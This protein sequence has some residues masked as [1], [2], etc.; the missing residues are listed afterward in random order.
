MEYL[1]TTI[2]EGIQNPNEHNK[3]PEKKTQNIFEM[4]RVTREVFLL[5]V[6]TSMSGYDCG[7][8]FKYIEGTV[9]KQKWDIKKTRWTRTERQAQW[10]SF[11]NR[12]RGAVDVV[13]IGRDKNHRHKNDGSVSSGKSHEHVSGIARVASSGMRECVQL[14]QLSCP[15]HAAGNWIRTVVILLVTLYVSSLK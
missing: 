12:L 2:P 5:A 10:K 1:S 14:G 3:W 7:E 15:D 8:I 6:P 4:C 11:Q 9:L 13:F